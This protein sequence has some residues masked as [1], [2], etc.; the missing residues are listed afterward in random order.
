[1]LN[2]K[3]ISDYKENG[4]IIPDFQL[5]NQVIDEISELYDRLLNKKP[6]FKNFCPNVLKYDL[7]FLN[8]ARIPEL[9]DLVEQ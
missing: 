5:S 7:G 4:Y 9:L 3:Q 1:M 8:F 6:E 2:E